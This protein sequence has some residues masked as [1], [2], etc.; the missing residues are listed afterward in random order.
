[1]ALMPNSYR[2]EYNDNPKWKRVKTIDET[3]E[4]IRKQARALCRERV[5]LVGEIYGN[6]SHV[7]AHVQAETSRSRGHR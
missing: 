3:M 4:K 7:A 1:M 5:Q 6:G 2:N